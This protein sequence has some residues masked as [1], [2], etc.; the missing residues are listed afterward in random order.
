MT[1]KQREIELMIPF[2]KDKE[3]SLWYS[4]KQRGGKYPAEPHLEGTVVR[5][6]GL[7]LKLKNVFLW[8][9]KFYSD[10]DVFIGRIGRITERK[11]K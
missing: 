9:G 5:S 11:N 8:N 3:I 10:Y 6:T 2:L 7:Y 4:M 1:K